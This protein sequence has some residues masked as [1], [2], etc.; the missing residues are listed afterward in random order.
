MALSALHIPTPDTE[1]TAGW[2]SDVVKAITY[3][4]AT[5]GNTT[6]VLGKSY[7]ANST[8]RLAFTLPSTASIGDRFKISSKN[9]GGWRITVPSGKTVYYDSTIVTGP[10]NIDSKDTY[11]AIEFICVTA[12]TVWVANS[13]TGLFG[14]KSISLNPKTQFK[15]YDDFIFISSSGTELHTAHGNW[16]EGSTGS[17]ASVDPTTTTEFGLLDVT[18]GSTSGNFRSLYTSPFMLG[19]T[20][21]YTVRMKCKIAGL[22]SGGVFHF[23]LFRDADISSNPCVGFEVNSAVNSNWRGKTRDGSGETFTS[24]TVAT[25]AN[26]MVFEII[27]N[28]A[29][30]SVEFKIDGV[31]LGSLTTNIPSTIMRAVLGEKTTFTGE[32]RTFNPDFYDLEIIGVD[33]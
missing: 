6:I 15:L 18:T 3:W 26:Y 8:S 27:M 33:R 13:S 17:T 9:T 10:D 30:T 29:G 21:N 20:P 7:I 2:G 31:S 22:G 1:I 28:N 12:D 14:D 5:T 24:T 16:F 4:E 11:S 25:T 19:N 23:G 32:S